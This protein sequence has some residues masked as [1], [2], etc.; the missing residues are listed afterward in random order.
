MGSIIGGNQTIKK[1]LVEIASVAKLFHHVW[2]NAAESNPSHDAML[3][4]VSQK[5]HWILP[6]RT[7]PIHTLSLPSKPALL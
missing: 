3:L 6:Y 5:V 2:S 4:V 1:L 7:N